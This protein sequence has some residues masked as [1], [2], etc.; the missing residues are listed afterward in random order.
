MSLDLTK[1]IQYHYCRE[2]WYESKILDEDF[3]GKYLIKYRLPSGTWAQR[4]VDCNS[5]KL[6]N[7]PEKKTYRSIVYITPNGGTFSVV[8]NQAYS[9]GDTFCGNKIIGYHEGE[10]TV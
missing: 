2:I 9:V 8:T 1:P 4:S 5:D 10:Y 3:N 7:V 6:R